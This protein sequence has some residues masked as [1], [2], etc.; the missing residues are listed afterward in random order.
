MDMD[1]HTLRWSF[2]RLSPSADALTHRFYEVLFARFPAVRPLFEGV[3][4]EDQQ[5]KLVRA[6]ALVVRHLEEPNFLQAYLEGLGAIHAAYGVQPA[7]YEAVREC[8]IAALAETAGASWTEP[9]HE[10]WLAAIDRISE[11]ML[12]GHHQALTHANGEGAAFPGG[13]IPAR[14]RPEREQ[15][16]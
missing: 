3:T 6:L 12:V 15:D 16:A 2:R 5:R 14:V 10:A 8:L 7:D 13:E 11:V 9:E 1:I 4:L